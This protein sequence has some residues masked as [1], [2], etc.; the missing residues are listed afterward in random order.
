VNARDWQMIVDGYRAVW[1]KR[2]PLPRQCA[3]AIERS[4]T[5]P[6][7]NSDNLPPKGGELT[8]CVVDGDSVWQVQTYQPSGKVSC[9]VFTPTLAASV[10]L[11]PERRVI[12]HRQSTRKDVTSALQYGDVFANLGDLGQFLPINPNNRHYEQTIR[13]DRI[14]RPKAADE[15]VW[16]IDYAYR[17]Q[18]DKSETRQRL[19]VDA[20]AD[21]LILDAYDPSDRG[22]GEGHNKLVTILGRKST[23]E[24]NSSST[25]KDGEWTTH[26]RIRELNP[27][28]AQVVREKAE[29]IARRRPAIDWYAALI[30]PLTLAIAWPATGLL[31][32]GLA[33]FLSMRHV[34]TANTDRQDRATKI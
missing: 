22:R 7:N 10:Y 6:P 30:Q 20:G 14:H 3:F 16:E 23:A 11:S 5:N 15:S 27:A 19:R 28:E 12:Q 25:D 33:R 13:I 21:W 29:E 24:Q 1:S 18:E 34:V 2:P 31:L 4:W 9:F 26:N 17:N 32:L 8:E